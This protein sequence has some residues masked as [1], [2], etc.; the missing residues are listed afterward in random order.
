MAGFAS[1]WSAVPAGEFLMGSNE[2]EDERPRAQGAD[3][4][5]SLGRR[6]TR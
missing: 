2:A 1:P 3:S 6:I 4:V 5:G